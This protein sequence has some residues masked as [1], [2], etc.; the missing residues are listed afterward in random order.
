MG[1]P[2]TLGAQADG[3]LQ[4]AACLNCGTALAGAYC[5]AC[6]Q[7]A[8][9][10]RT[11]GALFHD[12]LHGVLHFEGKVWRTLPLLA[13]RPGE[14]TRRYIDGQRAS[15]VSPTALFLFS[16][17]LMFA[18][19]SLSGALDRTPEQ[20]TSISG[21]AAKADQAVKRLEAERAAVARSGGPLEPIDERLAEARGELAA[22]NGLAGNDM[23]LSRNVTI[24]DDLPD[25]LRGPITR[26]AANPSLLFYKI[27]TNAYKFSWAL[28]PL[29]APF[30]WLL[31]PFSR[32]F[33]IYDHMVFV[34][35]S[36]SFMTLLVVA[37][38]MVGAVAPA[39]AGMA[40][41]IP[42]VHMYRQ[43]RGTYGIG[44]GAALWRTLLLVI[45][46]SVAAGLFTAMLF[47]LGLAS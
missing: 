46:A 17:F 7:H 44:R 26:S 20:A 10:H 30:L 42:P 31:F 9:A 5:H 38:V 33:G 24:S 11:L 6:G 29:S 41:L 16:V 47:G 14:L 21:A 37:A 35:Y 36:L 13:W 40:M 45:F 39:I 3:H 34:T 8:H 25:W 32:R 23:N 28:I 1:E 27:K 18:I 15:F 43:L 19:V 2:D 12:L 22:L 4:E